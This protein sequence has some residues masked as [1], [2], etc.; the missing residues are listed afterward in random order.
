MGNIGTL[1][2]LATG[3]SVTEYSVCNIFCDVFT[4]FNS[5]ILQ[6]IY[7]YLARIMQ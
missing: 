6:F 3:R 1:F 4:N 2:Y 5:N 7:V